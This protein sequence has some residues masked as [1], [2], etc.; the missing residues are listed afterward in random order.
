MLLALEVPHSLF[1]DFIQLLIQTFS[2]LARLNVSSELFHY[3]GKVALPGR[4]HAQP[5]SPQP[6]RPPRHCLLSLSVCLTERAEAEE[7][8]LVIN[9]KTLPVSLG[10]HQ[11]FIKLLFS[12]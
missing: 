5:R 3:L 9:H 6:G 7:L 8:K 4:A 11:S 12:R 10:F 2:S 1:S